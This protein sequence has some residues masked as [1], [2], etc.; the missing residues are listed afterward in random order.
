MVCFEVRNFF[1]EGNVPVSRPRV[2]REFRRLC[3]EIAEYCAEHGGLRD[4]KKGE[5]FGE[6]SYVSD[7][8]ASWQRVFAGRLLPYRKMFLG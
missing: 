5:R 3:R 8:D 7:G 6:Y 2:P 4:G 1:N